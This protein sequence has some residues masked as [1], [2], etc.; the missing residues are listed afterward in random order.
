MC[1]A[2]V[3]SKEREIKDV[4]LMEEKEGGYLVTTLLGERVEI[5][6]RIRKIDM[7]EHLV[8]VE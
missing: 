1:I 8:L 2:T 3:R 6:G 5:K 7:E 4:I